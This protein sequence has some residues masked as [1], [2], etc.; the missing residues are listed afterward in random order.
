MAEARE[1]AE[2]MRPWLADEFDL[3]LLL[4]RKVAA[5][6]GLAGVPLLGEARHF[7]HLDCRWVVYP[8]PS[9]V[10]HFWNDAANLERARRVLRDAVDELAPLAAANSVCYPTGVCKPTSRR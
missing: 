1:H 3:V 7:D 4:G 8:H 5:A 9:G 2:R 10:S 6:F